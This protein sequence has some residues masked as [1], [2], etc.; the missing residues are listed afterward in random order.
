[1]G[2]M[3]TTEERKKKRLSMAS[4]V[5]YD[6]EE[7][8]HM[9]IE[10]LDDEET[11]EAQILIPATKEKTCLS[12][13]TPDWWSVIVGCV[14]FTVMVL[15][16][17]GYDYDDESAAHWLA[18]H[19]QK[20]D[21]TSITDAFTTYTTGGLPIMYCCMLFPTMAALYFQ[22]KLTLKYA[23]SFTICW[24]ISL[25]CLTLGANSTLKDYGM[26]YAVT[27]ILIGFSITNI[28][29]RFID[30][31]YFSEVAS[32]G[33]W[34][35]KISL[36]T[37]AVELRIIKE[38]GL[39]GVLVGW[40]KSPISIWVTYLFGTKVIKCENKKL[41]LLIAVGVSWCG[42]SAITAV[43]PVIE[44]EPHDVTAAIGIICLFVFGWTFALPYMC[45]GADFSSEMSGAFLGA[46]VDQTANVVVSAAIVSQDA[47]EVAA[48]VKMILNASLGF[49]CIGV[50]L[51]WVLDGSQSISIFTLWEKF[52]K[53]VVGF[54]VLSAALSILTSFIL[55]DLQ[56]KVL[57]SNV[58]SISNW[59]AAL[60]FVC[61]GLNTNISLLMSKIP[62]G[63]IL[64]TY[65]VGGVF[66][67]CM[68]LLAAYVFFDVWKFSNL[69]GSDLPEP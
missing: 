7:G 31:S 53:F 13:I 6:D 43:A 16:C 52:P 68:S 51:S 9:V 23:G 30:T 27:S 2:R 32:L 46:S 61:I 40:I 60:G 19:P 18:P 50:T 5:G 41:C 29:G 48:T 38:Y 34:F 62:R 64:L 54:A 66:D 8:K 21:N 63:P 15:V 10:D 14:N 22:R 36:V 33:E 42:A 55:T 39:P 57:P 56:A 44:A 35:I 3:T 4:S 59:W 25:L 69:S 1:M 67:I 26:S 24:F 28:A 11:E 20:W 58:Q 45:K 12:G 47:K 17:V 49:M 65:L 37:L